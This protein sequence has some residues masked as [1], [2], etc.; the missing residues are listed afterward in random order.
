MGIIKTYDDRC[1]RFGRHIKGNKA[2]E[3]MAMII[4]AI[5]FLMERRGE[6]KNM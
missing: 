4:A 5:L 1:R 3:N 2:Q 6:K